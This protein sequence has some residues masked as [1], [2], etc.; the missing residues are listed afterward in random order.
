MSTQSIHRWKVHI[1]L[2]F[3]RWQYGLFSFVYQLLPPKYE[4]CGEI[5]RE[6]DLTA[7][8][9]HPRSSILVSM[10][11][12]CDLLLVS[13]CNFSRICYHFRDIHA[14]RKKT[15]HFTHPSLIWR[16]AREI[17]LEFLDETSLTHSLVDHRRWRLATADDHFTVFLLHCSLSCD[18]SFSWM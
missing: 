17:P 6:F 14:W 9:G 3:R 4:K 13:N 16:P 11:S 5:P 10:V 7:G 12:P 18:I 15:A 2:Q 1:G 8:Q